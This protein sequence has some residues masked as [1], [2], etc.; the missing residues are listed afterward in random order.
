M[1]P[2]AL[3]SISEV[4]ESLAAVQDGGKAEEQ[5]VTASSWASPPFQE[6][7]AFFPKYPGL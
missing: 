2:M 7:N 3:G 6:F 1:A 4:S 5:H